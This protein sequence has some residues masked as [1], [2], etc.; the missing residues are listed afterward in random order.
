VAKPYFPGTLRAALVS[1]YGFSFLSQ[2]CDLGF[3]LVLFKLFPLAGVG[4]FS[5]VMAVMVFVGLILDLGISPAL[6]REFSQHRTALRTVFWQASRLRL[7]GLLLN[8]V[9]F[10]I[11]VAGKRPQFE[12][13]AAMLLAGTGMAVHA[14][15]GVF[16]SWLY[17]QERQPEAN[18]VTVLS[19]AC[20][21]VM[22]V[23][24]IRIARCT[25]LDWLFGGL[26]LVEAICS[27]A[28]WML[29]HRP[30]PEKARAV[31]SSQPGASNPIGLRSRLRSVGI[32]FAVI[33]VLAALQNR[34]DW[35]MVS[36][37]LSVKALALY[38]M[39]NKCWE[40]CRTLI[41]LALSS[42][43][44]WMCRERGQV[45]PGLAVFYKGLLAGSGLITL[46]GA[47]IG[48]ETLSMFWGQK[49]AGSDAALRLL[50]L[51]V[52]AM[53]FNSV[54]YYLLVA[55][56]SERFIIWPMAIGT[57]AQVGVDVVLIPR[58]GILGAVAGMLAQIGSI[59]V[60]YAYRAWP[61][62]RALG[63][64]WTFFPVSLG[65]AGLLIAESHLGLW[66]RAAI[67]LCLWLAASFCPMYRQHRALFQAIILKPRAADE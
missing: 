4:E 32:S 6:T 65:A 8:L 41:N 51:S 21:L 23:G 19:S 49:Y 29:C 11:W 66:H 26:L 35:L 40:I 53:A 14:C 31:V 64:Y 52:A 9:L 47:L 12:L 62:L 42:A 30:M 44:P 39:A 33:T 18:F 16:T 67:G 37:F 20:R 24:L 46:A 34:L 27:G 63:L 10:G 25:N 55:G 7:P 36:H 61:Q 1:A 58:W 57:A 13:Q 43:F 54:L 15:T 38:S 28:G 56:G 17:A 59:G 50:M 60:V 48:P 45:S 22:G 5:W 3:Y 2:A